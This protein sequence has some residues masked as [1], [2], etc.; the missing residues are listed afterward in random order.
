MFFVTFVFVVKSGSFSIKEGKQDALFVWRELL[1]L[2]S[3]RC[4]I[5]RRFFVSSLTVC[6]LTTHSLTSYEGVDE[7]NFSSG[8]QQLCSIDD[9]AARK[10]SY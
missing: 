4:H 5:R 8:S 10:I 2:L 7:V 3:R 9:D 1:L 6:W